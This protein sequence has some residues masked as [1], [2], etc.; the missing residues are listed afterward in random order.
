[1]P[2]FFA[3]TLGLTNGTVNVTAA[4]QA[5]P[6]SAASGNHLVPIGYP[7]AAAAMPCAN[8]GD[9]IALPGEAN[10]GPPGQSKFSPGN[11]GG[12][13][14]NDGQQYTGSHFGDAVANGYQSSVPIQLGTA[15]N[16]STTTGSPRFR[17]PLDC[18]S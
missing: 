11:W 7:C 3:R 8:P 14:F 2:Y 9:S 12:L 17:Q 10:G 6:V 5:Q 16:V 18:V 1:V 15:S 4:A 13:A